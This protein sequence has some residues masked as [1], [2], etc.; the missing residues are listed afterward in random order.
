MKNKRLITVVV[1]ILVYLA[2]AFIYGKASGEKE[3]TSTNQTKKTTVVGVLQYVS[4]PALDEIYRGIKDGLKE[5][6]L[7]EG[8]NLEIKFQNGQADQSKLATMSQQ[9]VQSDP[10]VLIGIA[11]PAAQSLANTTS[12][13]PV[14]LG[15]VTDPVGVGLV[16]SLEKP[17]GNVTGVS[18]QPPVA[19]QIKLASDLLPNAK[20]VGILYASSEDNSK[21]Q[22]AQAEEA[23]KKEG[24]ESVKYA[25]P[26]TN[27]IAQTVQVMSR[28][29]DFIYVPLD[30]TIAN[31][32]QTVVKEA[33]KAN[34]PVIPSV[35]TMVEQGGLATI[36]INQY[37]LGLQSGK[38]AAELAS[39]KEKPETTPVYTF[40]Q[41]DT[42]INQSQ[43]DRLGIIVP[44]SMKEKAKIITDD[45]QQE[46]SKEDD[47]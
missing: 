1:I 13:I 18:D 26:S 21:Y 25:V 44:Q 6:G 15:A 20:K 30:N 5:E 45:S 7:K 27:E 16:A 32:M 46:T 10:D 47:K 14:V 29:V 12:S 39:G 17:G 28:Q 19:S 33:N 31:A 41:G 2:G 11:T 8:E 35:D 24:L 36:G 40:D 34:I 9:L 23:A 38:M 4:H 3:S 42:V 37:Q 43:A 22:V